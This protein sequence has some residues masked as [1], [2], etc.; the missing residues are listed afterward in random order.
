MPKVVKG[1]KSGWGTCSRTVSLGTIPLALSYWNNA[2]AAGCSNGN[3]IILNATT[4]S[5]IAILSGHT[6]WVRSVAFS[7]DGNSLVSGGYDETI[8]LWDMQT[9]GVVK[10]FNYG[11]ELVQSVSI[12]ADC[13]RIASGYEDW[14]IRLWDI[15][16]GK[17]VRTIGAREQV[18][19]VI[20][21]PIDPQHIIS[22]SNNKIQEWNANGHKI[23][24]AYD[25]VHIAFSPDH[26]L[27]ALCNEKA[28][29]IQNSGSREIVVE[30]HV[31]NSGTR[32][33][34]F[35]PDGKLIAVAAGNTAYVWN[36]TGP[37]PHPVETLIGHTHNIISLVF[38]SPSSLISASDDES[39]K[40][41][42]IGTLSK[43]PVTADQSS[44]PSTSPPVLSVSL[45]ARAGIAV[46]SDA[47]GV[48]KIWDIST[49]LCKASFQ[50][51]PL[52][53]EDLGNRDAKLIDGRLIFVWYKNNKIHIWDTGKEK[54]IKTL[55]TSWYR[56][57]RISEDGSWVFG[58]H[59]RSIQAWPM[60]KWKPVCEVK[61]GLE[62][63]LYLDFL[64]IASSK[65]WVQSLDSSGQEGWDFEKLH[66]SPVPFDPSIGRPH[67]DFIGGTLWQT[68]S[69]CWIK[70]TATGKEVFQL[71][72]KYVK[73]YDVQWDGQYLV[74]GYWSGGILIL[75]FGRILSRDI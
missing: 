58:L 38:S 14:G 45:Q 5:Q 73:P 22:V 54:I 12:S 59:D 69:P 51:P 50:I 46:S 25:G 33:C 26:S 43:D 47:D 61:L 34:C 11:C 36:I 23:P 9:G 56:G 37:G 55:D 2:I 66:S 64:S 24:P 48:V 13:T 4:G 75:D 60:W 70:D 1:S 40:F 74:A 30:F 63:R 65:V 57:I 16:T 17:L 7:S 8:K 52:Q 41:W 71:R 28:V 18:D 39:I 29:T 3:I 35:S 15:Q 31:A 49:G 19:Y 67:L 62:G 10:T 32:Y 72:G 21:S 27:F 68:N 44:T 53:E 6:D 42:K 20:F